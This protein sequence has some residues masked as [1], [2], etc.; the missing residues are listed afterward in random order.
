MKFSATSVGGEQLSQALAQLREAAGAE[1]SASAPDPEDESD[2]EPG[3]P[4]PPIV[5]SEA[6]FREK[7]IRKHSTLINKLDLYYLDAQAWW[8]RFINSIG[9]HQKK[10]L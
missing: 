5:I 4:P 3:P 7:G 2:D 1:P 8:H 10:D 9:L 6:D